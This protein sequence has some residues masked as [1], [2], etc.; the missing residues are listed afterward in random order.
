MDKKD[1]TGIFK[2]LSKAYNANWTLRWSHTP[3]MSKALASG[4]TESILGH[5]WAMMELWYQLRRVCPNLNAAIDSKKFY[6]IVLNH[7]LGET[8]LGDISAVRQ[9][10]GEGLDKHIAEHQELEKM[11]TD[12]PKY[13][14]RDMLDSFDE[15]E[16]EINSIDDL[17]ILLAKFI[18]IL[19]GDH[20]ALTFGNDLSK[21]ADIIRR[22]VNEKFTACVK[23]FVEVLE[24]MGRSEACKELLEIERF[25]INQIREAGIDIK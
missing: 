6:E 22:I 2:F 9:L 3:Y 13:S 17:E 1:L 20:F 24:K 12:L 5:K 8:F 21:H 7:D 10:N 25:H 11:S 14:A 18:D 4:K 15:F 19:Q 23:R 16:K